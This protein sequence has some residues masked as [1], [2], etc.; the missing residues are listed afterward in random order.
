MAVTKPTVGGDNDTWGG[1]LNA[2]LDA[3]DT[4][5]TSVE[6]QAIPDSPDDIGAVPTSRTVAGKPLTANITLVKGD[7]G[8]GN[9]DNTSDA[10]KPVSTAQQAALDGKVPTTR[11][12][13]G[14]A[15]SSNV[16]LVKGDVGLGNVDNTSDAAKPVST[17][18]Q[19]ALNTKLNTADIGTAVPAALPGVVL[20]VEHTG[21]AW[22]SLDAGLSANAAVA[23]HFVGGSEADPPPAVA[24]SAIW[25]RPTS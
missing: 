22:P 24:G 25:D 13:A 16:T 21:A 3:L 15:L 9:V 1:I 12:V 23:W 11:T 2:A 17:A 20:M 8:L 6:G 5:L 4:R 14:K 18:Q 10:D 7:V 19:T